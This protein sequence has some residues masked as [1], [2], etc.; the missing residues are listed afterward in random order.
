LSGLT[1]LE[2]VNIPYV[3]YLKVILHKEKKFSFLSEFI[4]I[5]FDDFLT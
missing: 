1:Y 4:M 2:R 3:T 5:F